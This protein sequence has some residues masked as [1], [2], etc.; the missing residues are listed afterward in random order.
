V[1]QTWRE[2]SRWPA[3]IEEPRRAVAGLSGAPVAA[4]GLP[5]QQAVADVL[6]TMHQLASPHHPICPVLHDGDPGRLTAG[7]ELQPM[8][9]Y[10]STHTAA[11]PDGE[12]KPPPDAGTA[13][14]QQLPGPRFM[15]RVERL[16]LLVENKYHNRLPLPRKRRSP[17]GGHVGLAH[18]RRACRAGQMP[19]LPH[20]DVL[21]GDRAAD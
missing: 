13:G 14:L 3:P 19:S 2:P 15:A 12:R 1:A 4:V 20:Q 5:H 9:G 17:R 11:Q 8:G 7:V 18:A 16:A 10:S 21:I 6:S